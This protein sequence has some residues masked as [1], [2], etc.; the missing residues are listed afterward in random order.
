[1]PPCFSSLD[2]EGILNSNFKNTSTC[3]LSAMPAKNWIY[4]CELD[5]YDFEY[6]TSTPVKYMDVDS[7]VLFEEI[8]KLSTEIADILRGKLHILNISILY[9]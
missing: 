3:L 1:M 7:S 2:H 6:S 8:N 4:I 5:S 9:L